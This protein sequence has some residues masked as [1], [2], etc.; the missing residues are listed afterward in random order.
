M[1]VGVYEEILLTLK[2]L[3]SEKVLQAKHFIDFLES[4]ACRRA[5]GHANRFSDLFDPPNLEDATLTA[6]LE[7]MDEGYHMTT[8]LT[9][10]T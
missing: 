2:T 4:Q 1:E 8:A 6:A 10:R 9:A 5:S 3:P 7:T